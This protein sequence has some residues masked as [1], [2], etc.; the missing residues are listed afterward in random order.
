[1]AV[2]YL[3]SR[4]L[5]YIYIYLPVNP[6]T[7]VETKKS[8]ACCSP[9]HGHIAAAINQLTQYLDPSVKSCFA[10][11]STV[12]HSVLSEVTAQSS[13]ARDSIMHIIIELNIPD[14]AGRAGGRKLHYRKKEICDLQLVVLSLSLSPSNDSTFDLLFDL[15]FT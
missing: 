2:L 3:Y 4:G 5:I 12:A 6:L 14:R 13:C 10:I 1:M 8:K 11:C 15:I 7:G 9:L